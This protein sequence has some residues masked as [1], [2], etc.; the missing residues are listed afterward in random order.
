MI[1]EEA[2]AI[3][4]EQEIEPRNNWEEVI[5][6]SDKLVRLAG[7]IDNDQDDSDA[8]ISFMDNFIGVLQELEKTKLGRVA[9]GGYTKCQELLDYYPGLEF[10]PE[11]HH[12]ISLHFSF[13]DSCLSIENYKIILS[14]ANKLFRDELV[15]SENDKKQHVYSLGSLDCLDGNVYN[16]RNTKQLMRAVISD[17]YVYEN[18][19]EF[20]TAASKV[21]DTNNNVLEDWTDCLFT[22]NGNEIELS[23]DDLAEAGLYM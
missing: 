5:K 11:G 23:L 18:K 13:P 9:I 20:K 6:N 1:S 16:F 10:I 3:A 22:T 14:K 12:A 7:D 17:K 8:L 15:L 21:F 2:A 4:L 19:I